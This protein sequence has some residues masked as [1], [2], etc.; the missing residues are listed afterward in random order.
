MSTCE[1]ADLVSDH[2]PR[3]VPVPDEL[4]Q[5]FW[6]AANDQK[7]VVQQCTKCGWMS[8]PPDLICP[9]CLA[10]DRDFTWTPLSGRGTL[11]SWTIVRTA[12]LPGFASH[13]P[14]V[15]AAV[16][17]EEQKGLRLTARL[18]DGADATLSYGSP[19]ETLFDE[20]A[21]GVRVPVFRLVG[22]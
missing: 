1:P 10:T 15:V 21:E 8:Y 11:R 7:L 19:V 9:N 16:E 13:V 6:D 22:R 2:H 5:G 3:P 12:F 14:Y 17:M 4:S 18:L 20:V